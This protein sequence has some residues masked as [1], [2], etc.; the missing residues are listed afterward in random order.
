[1]FNSSREEFTKMKGFSFLSP[2]FF[3]ASHGCKLKLG[4]GLQMGRQ[5][6]RAL[7]LVRRRSSHGAPNPCA[8]MMRLSMVGGQ[9]HS[10]WHQTDTRLNSTT[11]GGVTLGKLPH[12]SKAWFPHPCVWM[13]TILTLE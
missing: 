12:L 3:C 13:K 1:M 8:L 6:R 5:K 10:L 9:E 11:I 2:F 4:T 7:Q